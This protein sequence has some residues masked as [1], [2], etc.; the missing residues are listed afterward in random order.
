M[1]LR[2]DKTKIVRKTN[3]G[4]SQYKLERRKVKGFCRDDLK[5]NKGPSFSVLPVPHRET[6]ESCRPV[7][8]TALHIV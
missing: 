4:L 2:M 3:A 6:T 7:V 5:L 1:S 8:S